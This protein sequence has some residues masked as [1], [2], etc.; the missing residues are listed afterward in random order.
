[1]IICF[2][3]SEAE[4]PSRQ[5][6]E[7]ARKPPEDPTTSESEAELFGGIDAKLRTVATQNTSSFLVLVVR[8]AAT[9]SVLAP[10][11]DARCY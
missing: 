6:I 3:P 2:G 9:S 4:V 1:M 5:C 8:P 10:S 11:S 7:T